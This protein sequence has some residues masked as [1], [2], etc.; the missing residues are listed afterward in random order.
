MCMCADIGSSARTLERGYRVSKIVRQ[1]VVVVVGSSLSSLRLFA[2]KLY[3]CVCVMCM[4]EKGKKIS[5]QAVC[6][7]LGSM[8]DG[9]NFTF[10][11]VHGWQWRRLSFRSR[12]T[13]KSKIEITRIRL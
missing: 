7:G 3:V 11:G 8:R 10:G 13:A 12:R 5:R 6:V 4:S 9:R 2:K 1:V